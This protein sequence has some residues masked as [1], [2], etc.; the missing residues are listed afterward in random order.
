MNRISVILLATSL[1]ISI[2]AASDDDSQSAQNRRATENFKRA[3]AEL[4]ATF[5]QCL[6]ASEK[7]PAL[8]D[9]LVASQEAW[10][11]FRDADGR[12]ESISGEGGS[13]RS[14]YVNERMTYLTKQ[15]IYQ[16]KT[17]FAQGWLG[18]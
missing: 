10:L 7:S 11:T 13:A 6:A 14:Y 16:L 4:T 1:A 9:A 18:F 15:R 8:R 2:A 3:D 17:P 5:N 12:Y